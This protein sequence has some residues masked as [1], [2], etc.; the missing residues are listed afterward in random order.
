MTGA[1]VIRSRLVADR[2]RAR[3]SLSSAWPVAVLAACTGLC[4]DQSMLHADAGA[5]LQLQADWSREQ[6]IIILRR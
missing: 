6:I 5:V 2:R 1:D 4:A 3:R